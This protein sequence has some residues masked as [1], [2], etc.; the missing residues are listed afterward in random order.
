[1]KRMVLPELLDELPPED[2]GARRSRRDLQRLNGWM[3]HAGIMARALRE[4]RPEGQAQRVVELGAGDGRFLLSVAR[5]LNGAWA[6]TQAI[7]VDRLR[8]ADGEVGGRFERAGWRA[9]VELAEAG[10]WLRRAE[11]VPAQTVISNLFFHQFPAEPLAEL[12]RLAAKSANLVV[13]VEPRRAWLPGVCGR[14]LWVIGC[15]GVTRHDARISIRA[16]FAGRELTELW[17]E[18]AGWRLT[19]RPAGLF[20][21]LFIARRKE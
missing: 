18:R 11:R 7:L 1:M 20:S 3:G 16:G 4:N 2:A 9:R 15:N 14:L 12:L 5:R 10:E 6:G 19:E 21:H 17:P 8:V 13:A